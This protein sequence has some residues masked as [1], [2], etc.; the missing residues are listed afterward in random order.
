[1]VEFRGQL[2]SP[3]TLENYGAIDRGCT[4]TTT[5]GVQYKSEN[6]SFFCA[7]PFLPCSKNV[8]A[9]RRERDRIKD[10]LFRFF[11]FVSPT[12]VFSPI[13]C[14]CYDKSATKNLPVLS[15]PLILFVKWV[16]IVGEKKK[17]RGQKYRKFNVENYLTQRHNICFQNEL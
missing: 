8:S 14:L 17:K 5:F 1:M 13:N 11:V 9:K 4:T 10:S 7:V 6:S 16:G 3:P 2:P 15:G 12:L